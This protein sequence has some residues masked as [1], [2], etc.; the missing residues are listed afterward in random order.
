MKFG[1]QSFNDAIQTLLAE[2]MSAQNQISENGTK[3]LENV[4]YN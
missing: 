2:V 1:Y 3:V 4:I